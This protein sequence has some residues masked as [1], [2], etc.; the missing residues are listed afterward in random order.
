MK[1]EEE[2][3]LRNIWKF[4]VLMSHLKQYHA[5]RTA[6]RSEKMRCSKSTDKKQE[7][8]QEL[9]PFHLS[10]LKHIRFHFLRHCPSPPLPAAVAACGTLQRWLTSTSQRG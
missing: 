6:Q 8:L 4:D 3:D 7:S 9:D 2:E 10:K 5:E 1:K